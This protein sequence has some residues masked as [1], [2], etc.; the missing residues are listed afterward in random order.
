MDYIRPPHEEA[1]RLALKIGYATGGYRFKQY[2]RECGVRG[3][4]ALTKGR[5][6]YNL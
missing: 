3:K 5:G 6:Y 1:K 2:F 4:V